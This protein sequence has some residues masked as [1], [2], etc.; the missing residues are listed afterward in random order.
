MNWSEPTHARVQR[1]GRLLRY[2]DRL[3][4]LYSNQMTGEEA[5]FESWRCAS[6]CRCIDGDDGQTVGVCGVGGNQGN[7]VW[8]L[9]TDELLATESHRRQFIRGGRQWIDGLLSSG[10]FR[11]LEN[12]A[13]ASNTTTLRWLKHL[14]FTIDTPQPMGRS[15][16]L[17][18]H[19][20]RAA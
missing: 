11:V 20:W 3:E 19:F 12:W 1:V 15:C 17:F 10:Q 2:Q 6:I 5:V 4:V 7:L 8:L 9:A 14:G 18:S 13:L 16:Q